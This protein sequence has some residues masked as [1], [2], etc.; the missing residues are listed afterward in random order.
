MAVKR[1]APGEGTL[2]KNSRGYWVGGI[3]LPPGPDG[4]RR[5]KRVMRKSRNDCLDA[6]RDIKKQLDAGTIATA[7]STTVGKW[8][9]NWLDNILPQRDIKP[10]TV[11]QYGNMIRLHLKP[12]LGAKR[13][14]KLQ[15]ADIRAAYKAI[16]A[17]AG[18]RTAQKADQVLRLAIKSA[19]REGIVGSNVMD[20]VDKP[21]HHA[22]ASMAFDSL[23]ATHIITTAV[24]VQG[25]M[26][27]ARW[28]TGFLTGARESEVLGLEWSRVDLERAVIDI[29][30]QLQRLKKSHGCG[31]PVDGK[32]PCGRVR[33][34]FCP[35][36]HWDLPPHID[37]RECAGTLVWTTP[38]TRAG[39]RLIPIVPALVEILRR[40]QDDGTPNPHGLVFHHPDGRPIDQERD[41]K[42]WKELLI[43]AN[44]PHAP[45]HTV[46]HSTATLLLEAGV[47]AHVVQSVIGHTDIATTRGYMHVNL[48]LAR[49]AW[50]NLAAI[51]PKPV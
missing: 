32:F 26:W 17:S 25:A 31:D 7:P 9:D 22:R 44:V 30:W 6:L 39:Q 3:E 4:K 8:L 49:Q 48:D 18:G 51:M 11:Y 33:S 38:K 42:A 43:A 40:L 46:R 27:G 2:F 41:Q 35:Q 5:L 47:D 13:L 15:P 12:H 28:A 36:A 10:T 23:T 20:R 45:Q 29:S 1:R 50:A 21:T 37:Y 19:L 14:G 16:Q 24:D 34:G